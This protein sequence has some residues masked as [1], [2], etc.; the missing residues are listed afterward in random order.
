MQNKLSKEIAE[1]IAIMSKQQKKKTDTRLGGLLEKIRTK[2][3]QTKNE[4]KKV[5]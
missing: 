5:C 1:A 4:L 2:N 3:E